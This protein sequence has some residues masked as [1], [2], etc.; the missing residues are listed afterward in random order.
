MTHLT[1]ACTDQHFEQILALQRR[2]HLSR[3]SPELQSVEGFVFAEHTLP[4]L[5]RMAAE[6]PQAIAVD[7][8]R[9]VGYCLTLPMSVRDEVPSLAPMFDEF[10]NCFYRAKPLADYRYFVG[11]QVCVERDYRGQGLLARLYDTLRV[12]FAGERDLCVTDIATRNKVSMRAHERMGFERVHTYGDADGEWTI[13]AWD[14][15][16]PAAGSGGFQPGR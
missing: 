14:L 1:I 12:T 8:D 11:G 7:G 13:V 6:S 5:R 2:Y 10:T 4:L 16:R 3:V 9:V 15:A